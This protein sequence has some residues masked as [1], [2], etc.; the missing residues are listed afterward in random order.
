MRF[1]QT[2]YPLWR[3]C[4]VHVQHPIEDPMC[5]AGAALVAANDR[6]IERRRAHWVRG[7][8]RQQPARRCLVCGVLFAASGHGQRGR[9]QELCGADEC[10]RSRRALA[11]RNRRAGTPL[12]PKRSDL[13]PL[14]PVYRPDEGLEAFIQAFGFD[15]LYLTDEGKYSGRPRPEDKE[16]P[17]WM[18]AN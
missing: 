4:T 9:P 13:T 14:R 15:F 7:D 11:A 3:Y 12:Q 1:G 10:R 2:P 17:N 5:A 6:L 18:T 8:K 16:L